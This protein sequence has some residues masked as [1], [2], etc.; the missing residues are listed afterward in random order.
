MGTWSTSITGNDTASDLRAEYQAAFFSFDIQTSLVKIDEYVRSQGFDESNP[1]EWCDYYYS[2]A[3]FMW[4]HGI[5]TDAVRDKA[6]EMIHSEYGLSCWAE[7][8]EKMLQKRKKVL[9]DFAQKLQSPQGKQKKIRISLYLSSVFEVGDV[10][11]FQLKTKDKTFLPQKSHFDEAF[12]RQADGKFVI[13]RKIEDI[14]GYQSALV[15][16]IADHWIRFQLHHGIFDYIPDISEVSNSRWLEDEE[17]RCIFYCES[18]L[19]YFKRRDYRVIGTSTAGIDAAKAHAGSAGI[20]FSIN[21]Q[22]Y[23]AD[24]LL[25]NAVL[26]TAHSGTSTEIPRN[27]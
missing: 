6:L 10:V 27:S 8:G 2:L 1:A 21:R 22:H 23:N 24:T 19:Y 20:F 7:S 25:L 18:N 26:D 12:F 3:D 13:A 17:S 4:N 15:P 5:L 14:I 11:A 9:A 16:E